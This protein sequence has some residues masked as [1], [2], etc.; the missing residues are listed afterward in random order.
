M[1]SAPSGPARSRK[2]GSAADSCSREQRVEQ[3]LTQVVQ[4][5]SL[6]MH[7]I[8]SLPRHVMLHPPNATNCHAMP[9]HA[10]PCQTNPHHAAMPCHAMPCHAVP[11]HAM[12]CHAGMH[13]TQPV[14]HAT[15]KAAENAPAWLMSWPSRCCCTSA[16]SCSDASG[17]QSTIS[18]SACP[19]AS[20]GGS[21]RG[22]PAMLRMSSALYSPAG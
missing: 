18:S 14:Q 20:A 11:C 22:S 16:T 13:L 7:A 10:M 17:A 19:L 8:S 15:N 12:P 4:S 9:C 3:C 21:M 6:A 5:M 1:A 2:A